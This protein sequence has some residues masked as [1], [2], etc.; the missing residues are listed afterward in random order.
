MIW[1]RILQIILP[2]FIL[3]LA[4]FKWLLNLCPKLAFGRGGWLSRDLLMLWVV[5]LIE[6]NAET[7]GKGKEMLL[8]YTIT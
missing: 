4:I 1:S 6:I 8:V 3:G 7:I 2:S 5:Q